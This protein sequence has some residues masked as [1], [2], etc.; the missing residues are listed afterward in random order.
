MSIQNPVADMFTR[1]RNGQLS[2]KSK[3][4]MQYSKFKNAIAQILKSEGYIKNLSII[5][6]NNILLEIHLK[7]FKGKG[8]IEKIN[9]ISRPGLRIYKKKRFLPK[10]I[11][12][13]GIAIVSTS[14][15]LMTDYYARQY[16]LGG[17]I[18]CYVS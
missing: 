8:V 12:G 14:K 7:Y 5:N 13:L 3:I 1:I 4:I 17:E 9:C 6:K 18:I 11:A 2:N 16:G 10:V 15:G